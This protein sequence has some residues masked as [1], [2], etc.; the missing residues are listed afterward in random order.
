MLIFFAITF[1]VL[2]LAYGYVGWRIII[3]AELNSPWSWIAWAVL[4]LFLIIPYVATYLHFTGKEN[5][6]TDVL[7]WIGYI[8]L[9]FF[10]LVFVFV[11]AKDV[12]WLLGIAGEKIITFAGNLFS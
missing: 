3:P 1:T 2:G 9:G 8:G 12:I 11:L 7:S 5:P 6:F 4:F 10:S